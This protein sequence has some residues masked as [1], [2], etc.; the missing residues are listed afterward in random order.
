[1][2]TDKVLLIAKVYRKNPKTQYTN[3]DTRQV[4]DSYPVIFDDG[5]HMIETN[6]PQEIY[7]GI[8]EGRTYV[9]EC[10]LNTDSQFPTSRFKFSGINHNVPSVGDDDEI[11]FVTRSSHERTA[12][13][14]A[15]KKGTEKESDAKQA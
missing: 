14:S 10:A 12:G 7:D 4:F 3:P 9:F 2:K 6:I 11:I 1:M 5:L 8:V 13:N 15:G